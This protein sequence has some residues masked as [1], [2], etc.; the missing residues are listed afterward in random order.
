[1]CFKVE[2][3]KLQLYFT[4]N[5][6]FCTFL[7]EQGIN[8]AGAR[9]LSK[10]AVGLLRGLK[11]SIASTN[12]LYFPEFV[13]KDVRKNLK[14]L[15]KKFSTLNNNLIERIRKSWDHKSKIFVICDD[16]LIPRYT[17]KA[18]RS[19]IFRDPV[20]KKLELVIMS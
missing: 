14:K 2:L 5:E 12:R 20:K 10:L 7:E 16:Y 11:K 3:P 15:E 8:Y 1:M 9:Q 17:K 13:Y 19:S 4:L 18:Y 6:E